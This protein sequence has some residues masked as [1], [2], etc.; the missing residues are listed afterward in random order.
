MGTISTAL[1]LAQQG[2]TLLDRL[3][4]LR[5]LSW[6]DPSAGLGFEYV[7]PA[8]LWVLIGLSALLFAGWSY[9]RLLGQRSLRVMLAVVRAVTLVVLVIL[10]AGPT[11]VLPQ[12]SVEEDWLMVMID[13]SASMGVLDVVDTLTGEP[14]SRDQ[15]V[16]DALRG[17]AEVFSDTGL[18]KGR[19]LVWL[20]FG[21]SAYAI[22]SP[23]VEPGL[24]EP[25]A[26]ATSI[27]T[28]IEQALR[29]PSGKPVSGV[30]LI[31]DGRTPQ[32]TGPSLAQRL[33]QQGV[34]VFAVPVGAVRPP[35]DLAIGQADGP[36]RTFVN[37]SAPVLVTI[38]QLG[39]NPVDPV[40]ISVA[41][42][43][44]ADG[45]VLDEQTLDQAEPGQALRLSGKS[46]TV[47]IA[48]WMVRVTHKPPAGQQPL[49]E[50]VIENNTRELEV[51]VIDRPIR[52]LYVE[53]YPRWEFRYLK[54]LLIREKSI[55]ASTYLLSADRSFAQEGDVPIT[56]LPVDAK[57]MDA[58]DVVIL[59]DVPPDFFHSGQL[60]ILR[61]HI[62]A[63]GAGLIWIGGEYHT[64]RSYGGTPLVDLLPMRVPADVS[65][66]GLSTSL[67]RLEPTALARSLSVMRI[68]GVNRESAQT[69]GW[70]SDLPALRW[71]QDM[72]PLKPTAE[73]IADAISVDAEGETTPALVRLRYGAGQSLYVGTDEAWRWRYGRGE[74]YFEQYWV[75]LIRMLG[76][77][78]VQADT[79][80]ALFRV[81]SRGVSMQQPVVVELELS[82]PLL[83]NR[84]LSRIGVSVRR[85]SA[86]TGQVVDS[87]ELLPIDSVE[88][89]APGAP[90]RVGYRAI[91][92]PTSAGTR[93][94]TVTEPALAELGLVQTVRVTAADDEMLN[95]RSDHARLAA[96]AEQTG[97]AVVALDELNRLVGLVPNRARITPTD[98]REPL[99]DSMLSLIVLIV[100][101]SLEW[102]VRRAIRLA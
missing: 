90:R 28:A 31:T 36:Q 73:V 88:G 79:D 40:E 85:A 6:S 49:R 70:P 52:V 83:I 84:G 26:Q 35:L 68:R 101:F 21:G 38:E 97:G 59:G 99:W 46:S 72:G 71:V 5:E 47:G 78:R 41:L 3:L 42:I 66:F 62:S 54:N 23:L 14:I 55:S 87:L 11:L 58:Y 29:L 82:D 100:L 7:L 27:R 25:D 37:D 51:E 45:E 39:G 1:T 9:R 32:D 81:S 75:Q 33:Q 18:G 44:Q 76:R 60:S 94:L 13:R 12:E 92:R 22:Q 48:R 74:W 57:E 50:L 96:L 53:G 8:W 69:D 86:P 34:A 10:L 93:V 64:P 80:R 19:R 77:S 61:D 43:D 65:R 102:V 95:P 91:W 56:R 20:G 4:G 2:G 98:I 16:R 17:Q 67:F 30:V 89:A 15:S 63:G 24:A